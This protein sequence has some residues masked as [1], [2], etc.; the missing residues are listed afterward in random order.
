MKNRCHIQ[1]FIGDKEGKATN[2]NNIGYIYGQISQYK[3][4]IEYYE[5]SLNIRKEIG[6][7]KGMANNYNNIAVLYSNMLGKYEKAIKYAKKSV[8]IQ[9]E[10]ENMGGEATSIN[11]LGSIYLRHHQFKKAEKCFKNAFITAKKLK[12]KPLLIKIYKN[13]C[14]VEFEKK[15]KGNAEKYINEYN[16]I[17]DNSKINMDKAYSLFLY[18]RLYAKK[19]KMNKSREYFRKSIKICK[20]YGKTYDISVIYY[21]YAKTLIDNESQLSINNKNEI[22]KYLHKAKMIFTKIGATMWLM[23]VK[24]LEKKMLASK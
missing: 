11:N 22:N 17:I 23:E 12:Y 5:Y 14:E 8:E 3:F 21:C 9:N 15:G 1:E 20:K 4:A 18:G 13:L 10:I 24:K 19:N 16:K 2:L 6:D 7:R